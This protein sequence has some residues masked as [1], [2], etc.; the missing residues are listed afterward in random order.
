[1][2]KQIIDEKLDI[3]ATSGDEDEATAALD[4]RET[5]I[6]DEE[7]TVAAYSTLTPE[8]R[9]ERRLARKPPIDHLPEAVHVTDDYQLIPLFDVGDRI[10][11]ERYLGEDTDSGWFDT[12]IL[13]VLSIEDETG[14]V[15][16]WDEEWKQFAVTGF[17]H[18]NIILKLAPAYGNPFAAPKKKAPVPAVNPSSSAPGAAKKGRGRPKGSKNR[19]KDVVAAEKQARREEKQAKKAR[20]GRR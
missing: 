14:V 3:L 16:C 18:P 1:M 7:E 8:Q 2:A 5:P 20:R 9:E 12:R 19:S 10:V 11:A 13:K 4:H 6:S 15:K 17:K